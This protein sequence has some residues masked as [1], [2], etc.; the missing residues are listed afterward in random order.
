MRRTWQDW[1]VYI[2]CFTFGIA[3]GTFSSWFHH[4]LSDYLEKWQTFWASMI[5]L[6]AAS[7]SIWTMREGQ[8]RAEKVAAMQRFDPKREP[9]QDLADTL[10]RRCARETLVNPTF[11][12]LI[13][14]R[15]YD[16]IH[17]LSRAEQWLKK[18][19]Y[20]RFVSVYHTARNTIRNWVT[21]CLDEGLF[22]PYDTDQ[23]FAQLKKEMD[24]WNENRPT[25]KPND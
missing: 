18:D 20:A 9:M 8:H 22:V 12:A 23:S 1:S 15:C 17:E 16:D 10:T 2:V 19:E 24:A 14:R 3:V 5:A 21:D 13:P 7:A 6:T 4:D 11:K 25:Q